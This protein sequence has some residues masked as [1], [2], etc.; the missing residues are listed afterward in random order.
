M[1]SLAREEYDA[2]FGRAVAQARRILGDT[3]RAE[4]VASEA[5]GKI[6]SGSKREHFNLI[7]HGLAVDAYRKLLRE[8]PTDWFTD[9]D[10]LMFVAQPLTYEQ[11]E[12]RHDFDGAV[13]ALDDD[14]RQAFLLTYVRGLSQ[15]EA[16]QI[17]NTDQTTVSRRAESA[18][19]QIKEAIA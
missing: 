7:V 2:L 18:R 8:Q 17:L 4:E 19:A 5:I 15:T 9:E 10:D 13:R 1:H 11:V 6:L 16:A 3:T 12:F 14:D